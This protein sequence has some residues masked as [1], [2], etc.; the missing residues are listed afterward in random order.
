MKPITPIRTEREYDAALAE[1]DRLWDAKPDTSAADR[2]DV[3]TTLVEAYEATRWPISP[4]DPINAIVFRMEQQGLTRRD[5]EPYLGGRGHV[6]EVLGRKRALSL[7]MIRRLHAGLGIPLESL[8]QPTVP[9][10]HPRS[11]TRRAA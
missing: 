5:L 9:G 8:I 1:I 6:S 4:P 10:K 2:L 7:L 11:R 3:L